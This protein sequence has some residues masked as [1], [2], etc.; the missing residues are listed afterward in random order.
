MESI[1]LPSMD[2]A[3]TTPKTHRNKHKSFTLNS[4][5]L[6]DFKF[7][8]TNAKKRNSCSRSTTSLNLLKNKIER[9]DHVG[10]DK[11]EREEH[12]S[13]DDSRSNSSETESS[14]SDIKDENES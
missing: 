11:I 14:H 1:N 10:R 3:R 8:A 7:H 4:K 2:T 13:D 6:K 12:V 5:P 9:D